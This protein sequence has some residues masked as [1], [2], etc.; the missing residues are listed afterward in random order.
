MTSP[1]DRKNPAL[2]RRG[3]SF[4]RTNA[5]RTPPR[6]GEHKAGQW[7]SALTNPV[8]TITSA[9]SPKSVSNGRPPLPWRG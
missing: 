9:T 1:L 3:L 4:Q 2:T 8:T 5:V 7:V 6:G